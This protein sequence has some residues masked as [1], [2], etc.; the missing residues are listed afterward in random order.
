MNNLDSETIKPILSAK[1][2]HLQLYLREY[3]FLG[4][5]LKNTNSNFFQKIVT[6]Y[7]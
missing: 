2:L 5:S 3:F 6:V 1:I 7:F 4:K